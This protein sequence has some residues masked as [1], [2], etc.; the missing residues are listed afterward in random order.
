MEQNNKNLLLTA[1][2]AVVVVFA[3]SI[4]S[5]TKLGGIGDGDPILSPLRILN[6]NMLLIAFAVFL[7]IIYVWRK[8]A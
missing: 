8:D 7:I 3:F 5:L 4:L 6:R 1:G 2:I